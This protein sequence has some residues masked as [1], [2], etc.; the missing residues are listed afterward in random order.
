MQSIQRIL[1][2]ALAFSLAFSAVP[3][4]AVSFLSA[5]EFADTQTGYMGGHFGSNP[6]VGFLSVTRD[7]GATFQAVRV[8]NTS[9]SGVAVASVGT[10]YAASSGDDLVLR[11]TNGGVTWETDSPVVGTSAS[12]ADIATA[13]GGVVAVGERTGT[14]DGDLA[15]IYSSGSGSA[16]WLNRFTGPIYD[17]PFDLFGGH[18]TERPVTYASMNEVAM[19]PSG[20]TGWAF[21]GEWSSPTRSVNDWKNLLIKKTT[22]GGVTWSDVTNPAGGLPTWG[23]SAAVA[24][25]ETHAYAVGANNYLIKTTDGSNWVRADLPKMDN[26]YV[27]TS[28]GGIDATDANH[29]VVVG[30]SKRG[31]AY[32]GTVEW[33]TDGGATWTPYFE[34]GLPALRAVSMITASKWIVIGEDETIGRTSDAGDTW[35]FT[36]QEPPAVAM[37]S[38]TQGEVIAAPSVLVEGTASDAGAGVATVEVSVRRG[39]GQYWSGSTWVASETWNA[40]SPSP[41]GWGSWTWN[42]ALEPGQAGQTYSVSSRATDAIGLTSPVVVRTGIN[43][44]TPP[45]TTKPTVAVSAPAS[46]ALLTGTQTTIR[47]TAGDVGGSGVT[48]VEVAI[49]RDDGKYWNGSAWSNPL[50]P[51]LPASTTDGW[52]TWNHR[53]ALELN[54]SGRT[55]TIKAQATD[56]GGNTQTVQSNDVTVDTRDTVAPVVSVF[57]P[58]SSATLAGTSVVITGAASDPGG[59]GVKSVSVAIQRSDGMYWNGISWQSSRAE[60]VAAPINDWATWSWVWRFDP[61]VQDGSQTYTVIATATDGKT[62][63]QGV[64]NVG[65]AGV[66]NVRVSNVPVIIPTPTLSASRGSHA[67]R[68]RTLKTAMRGTAVVVDELLLSASTG[69]VSVGGLRLTG[70]D[71]TARLRQN[72]TRVALYRD[73]GDGVFNAGD[74]PL[75]TSGF[76]ANTRT[77]TVSF[78]FG[79][80]LVVQPTAPVHVWVVYRIARN[81][82]PGATLGSVVAVSGIAATAPATVSAAAGTPR[83]IVSA[84]SGRTIRVRR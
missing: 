16:P 29:I 7:G 63:I 38:P 12:F 39:D 54:Q 77:E 83:V 70:R 81:A 24:V 17:W 57:T 4:S 2:A 60:N 41:T 22:D 66:A 5:I 75:A 82:V 9:P 61:S 36:R 53:W 51:W 62:G 1:S 33:T 37:T 64:P 55:Y 34:D 43:V 18:P 28:A 13:A 84:N 19:T 56:A 49:Q 31:T 6:R 44:A 65:A 30:R 52:A 76:T 74:A 11:T 8:N 78:P 25:D 42:W 72:V 47:G 67:A 71:N 45:D 27:L 14:I 32:P 69:A 26:T 48:G 68:P 59:T 20:S 79:A 40:A 46:N 10:A 58:L 23:I 15:T 73:N 80:P 50:V 3:A 35:T 21:G